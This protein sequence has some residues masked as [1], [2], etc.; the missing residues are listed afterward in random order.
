MVDR[1][2]TWSIV[3]QFL[4]K[5][6]GLQDKWES[7]LL[8]FLFCVVLSFWVSHCIQFLCRWCLSFC[9]VLPLVSWWRRRFWCLEPIL[10]NLVHVFQFDCSMRCSNLACI[11]I[12]TL[13]LVVWK[14]LCLS[15]I[16]PLSLASRFCCYNGGQWMYQWTKSFALGSQDSLLSWF[17]YICTERLSGDRG[18]LLC[19]SWNNMLVLWCWVKH[20][21]NR[22]Y[23]RWVQLV[24]TYRP[25]D[26]MRTRAFICK[27]LLWSGFRMFWL[28]FQLHSVCGNLVVLFNFFKLCS[29]MTCL[30]ASEISCQVV[31]F[32]GTHAPCA[33]WP[34]ILCAL[35]SYLFFLLWPHWIGEVSIAIDFTCHHHI[36]IALLE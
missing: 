4:A 36:F 32:L 22:E 8:T 12:L 25:R 29:V 7:H 27:R 33:V 23:W 19:V 26:R 17:M 18:I 21:I 9:H 24:A 2:D 34:W 14:R 30:Y 13:W 11:C 16:L 35:W 1:V 15:L 20:W 5:L 6:Q 10:V 3:D 31:A 28:L